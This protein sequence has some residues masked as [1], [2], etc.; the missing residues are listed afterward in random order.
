MDDFEKA[1]K[2]FCADRGITDPKVIEKIRKN[3]RDAIEQELHQKFEVANLKDLF[4][5]GGP[6]RPTGKQIQRPGPN[7]M[8]PK[9][10]TRES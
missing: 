4:L 2:S 7:R 8:E 3:A 5:S 6:V 10:Y 1:L 9:G